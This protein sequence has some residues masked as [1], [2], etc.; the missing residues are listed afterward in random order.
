MAHRNATSGDAGMRK[1]VRPA[2]QS[3]YR[4]PAIILA[5]V[6]MT[7]GASASL[8]FGLVGD[9]SDN[10]D[11]GIPASTQVVTFQSF[12]ASPSPAYVGEEVTF[13]VNASSNTGTSLTFTI[14]FD[15]FLPGY[16][17]NPDSGVSVNVTG[18]PGSVVQK[19]TY[20]SLGNFTRP[21]DP[22]M[23]YFIVRVYVNDGSFNQS[24]TIGVDVVLNGP[25]EFI[26]TPQDADV[27]VDEV[28]NLTVSVMD[29]DGDPVDVLWEFGDGATATNTTDGSF[30]DRYVNQTHVWSPEVEQGTGDYTVEYQLNVTISDVF[31]NNV[32]SNATIEVYVPANRAPTIL[33]TASAST[34]EPGRSV[35]FYGNATDP[36]GDPLTWTFNYSDGTEEVVHTDA[37]EPGALAWC[38]VTHV[39]EEV[40]DYTIRMNVSDALG[41]NQVF[42]HNK[43]DTVTVVVAENQ[44]PGVVTTINVE[45]GSIIINSTIGYLDVRLSISAWEPDGENLTAYWYLDN[46]TEPVVNV[47]AGGT[48]WYEFVQVLRVTE[49][50]LYN[51][52]VVVT[53]GREGH[54]T[55]V[56][57]TLNATSD[58]MPPN[59][60]AFD[61][62]YESGDKAIPGEEIE[63][64]L[65]ISDRENDVIE[66]KV[67]FGDGTAPL[68]LN[69]TDYDGRNTTR[70][71]TH[72]YQYPGS[73]EIA[74]WFS[75][76]KIGFFQEFHT[77][78]VTVRVSVDEAFVEKVVIWDWWDYTS[79]GTVF[80]V[81]LIIVIRMHFLK[82]RMVRLENEGMTLEE[83][84]MKK[85]ELLLQRLIEGG[86]G[87]G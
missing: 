13:W 4:L 12:I 30:E 49:T 78:N 74:L 69:L 86:E 15:M 18:N 68:H 57:H 20:N 58:N 60:V 72:S 17:P 70:V 63:F 54:E 29:P 71:F 33:L 44:V 11:E 59:L 27:D 76:N 53:D 41:D 16:I 38:N 66:A 8:M 14:F 9:H 19:F 36:E 22:S 64:T 43:S 73:Y 31:G 65:V 1:M 5:A 48:A 79:L 26:S 85:D 32:T 40:G 21:E 3:A 46:A 83:A 42:P 23:T 77:Q 61:F 52:T 62:S 87:G 51:V 82:R 80:A 28:L 67:D 47:S 10:S 45:P 2:G 55:T 84:Q 81:P 75:D 50:R 24:Q 35:T 37:T 56:S 39:F 25:P 6:L 34:I 7:V